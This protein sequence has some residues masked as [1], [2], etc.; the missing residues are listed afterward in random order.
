M[1]L[2]YYVNNFW[3]S[4]ILAIFILLIFT[5]AAGAYTLSSSSAT[6]SK[7]YKCQPS[8]ISATFSDFAAIT[9]VTVII[10]NKNA[11]LVNGT[12][13]T[14]YEEYAMANAGGGQWTYT[15]GNDP[16]IVWGNKSISFNVSTA[17]GYAINTTT[18]YVFVYSD[19]CTGTGISNVSIGIGNYTNRLARDEGNLLTFMIQPFVD[20]WGQIF[21]VLCVFAIVMAMYIKNQHVGPPLL[22]GV[23]L[24]GFLAAYNLLPDGWKIYMAI[25]MAAVIAGILW[26]VFKK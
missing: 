22:T 20:Y 24:L 5:V 4:V 3:A 25:I 14:P 18:S 17:G 6:P 19:I 16:T 1:K 21:Y 26:K 7:I 15:Y 11:I 13:L 12:S 9:A 23:G 8:V 10:E 2:K